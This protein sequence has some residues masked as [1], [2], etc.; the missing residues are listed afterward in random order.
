M[1][2]PKKTIRIAI[3]DL[4]AGQVNEGMRCLRDLINS[5]GKSRK[6]QIILD[7]F[8][9][10]QHLQLPDMSYDIYISSGGP[11]SP[12]ESE[13]SEWEELYFNWLKQTEHWNQLTGTVKK[14]VLFIC[15]SFEII[16]RHYKIANVCKRKSIAFGVFPVH[17][18][19][20][21]KDE[22]TFKG[23]KDPFYALDSRSYQV[24]EPNRRL[25]KK[26]G[27]KVLAIEKE[28]PHVPLERSIMALRFN[29]HMLGTQFH[30]EADAAGTSKYLKRKDKKQA[31]IAEHG[32][33]K[34]KS[35]IEY[36]S[37]PDKILST[38]S[39]FIPNFLEQSISTL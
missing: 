8:E 24:I 11:G 10:R 37:D 13:G 3:L 26:M 32:E 7:E 36:L 15:H 39:H 16:C 18:L 5:F 34:W 20:E 1:R 19:P 21:G 27:A 4:Y 6:L 23:L 33:A 2:S 25:L 14:K 17:L 12:L 38:Y 28:R 35:M 29:E 30:P 31:V 22:P 9:V